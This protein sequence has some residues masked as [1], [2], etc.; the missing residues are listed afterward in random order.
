MLK[1]CPKKKQKPTHKFGQKSHDSRGNNDDNCA[2]SV[3]T[4]FKTK[5]SKLDDDD[6]WLTDSGASKHITCHRRWLHNFQEIK[7]ETVT[8]GD[9]KRVQ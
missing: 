3:E 4:D 1:Y 7:T 9:G 5:L 6:V 2:F 8:V